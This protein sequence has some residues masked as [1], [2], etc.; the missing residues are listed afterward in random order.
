MYGVP[1]AHDILHRHCRAS[2]N[3]SSAWADTSF[4]SI[5]FTENRVAYL[6]LLE[7]NAAQRHE[8]RNLWALTHR[9]AIYMEYCCHESFKRIIND[10]ELDIY[11]NYI[12]LV[13]QKST[14]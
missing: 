8:T 13:I 6:K 14:K 5:I 11:C 10:D 1:R 9:Y 4:G 7:F 3:L 12:A 2:N